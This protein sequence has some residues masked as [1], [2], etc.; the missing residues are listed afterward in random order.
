MFGAAG[1]LLMTTTSQAQ[2][3]TSYLNPKILSSGVNVRAAGAL[4]RPD[5]DVYACYDQVS[6]GTRALHNPRFNAEGEIV[7][8]GLNLFPLAVDAFTEKIQ[9]LPP[10]DPETG[11]L[12]IG[13]HLAKSWFGASN[14]TF[15]V[16]DIGLG[17]NWGTAY[18][19][20]TANFEYFCRTPSGAGHIIIFT[21]STG[22]LTA[23]LGFGSTGTG[24]NLEGALP[25]NVSGVPSGHTRSLILFEKYSAHSA[26][27]AQLWTFT[28]DSSVAPIALGNLSQVEDQI[29]EHQSDSEI[30]TIGPNQ[31]MITWL[32]TLNNTRRIYAKVVN[33][34]G[35]TVS[36]VRLIMSDIEDYKATNSTLG[37]PVFAGV[38]RNHAA[39]PPVDTLFGGL[40]DPTNGIALTLPFVT[41]FNIKTKFI[42]QEASGDFSLGYSIPENGTTLLKVRRISGTSAATLW[43]TTVADLG[44]ASDELVERYPNTFVS[45]AP[46]NVLYV[47]TRYD[48]PYSANSHFALTRLRADGRMGAD[49]PK[50]PTFFHVVTAEPGNVQ[51]EWQDNSNIETDYIIGR[52]LSDFANVE[53]LGFAPANTTTYTDTTAAPNTTYT[54]YVAAF[55]SETG[56]YTVSE[57]KVAEVGAE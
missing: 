16:Q 41:G 48:K 6:A 14:F 38:Q 21:P 54:Y 20:D 52:T 19:S 56:E 10:A 46:E 3:P 7:D 30:Y 17:D 51:L 45:A 43:E 5:G 13:A 27:P 34:G 42:R 15:N 28:T 1:L 23:R 22:E 37:V 49:A 35:E 31:H 29:T 9:I 53:I 4:A 55:S 26:V 50:M 11:N 36:P 18:H 47:M 39:N 57:P 24:F 2:W 25:R 44:T 8:G 33:N 40:L 12:T 32:G